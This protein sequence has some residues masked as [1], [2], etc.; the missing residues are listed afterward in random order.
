MYK[1]KIESLNCMSC[2]HKI[3]DAF[4]EFDSSIEAKADVKSRTLTVQ[5]TQSAEQLTKLIE[6]AGYPVNEVTEG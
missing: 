3:E 6:D 1:F 4:K 5:S 2:F